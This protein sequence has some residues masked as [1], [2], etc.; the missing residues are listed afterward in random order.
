[1]IRAAVLMLAM[2]AP[3]GA[4]PTC[5][6]RAGAAAELGAR[7]GEAVLWGGVTPEGLL[8]QGWV[9]PGTGSWTVTVTTAAGVTC[10]VAAGSGFE[11]DAPPA[12]VVPGVPG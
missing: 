10:V 12:A 3:A 11:V 8:V 9:N 4:G 7:W 1:M 6:A 2:A 5:L